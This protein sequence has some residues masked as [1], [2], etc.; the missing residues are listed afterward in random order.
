MG[1]LR[2]LEAYGLPPGPP[3]ADGSESRRTYAVVTYGGEACDATHGEGLRKVYV[4]KKAGE[5]AQ[6]P[7][8]RTRSVV[9]CEPQY[10][11]TFQARAVV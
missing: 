9:G 2:V 1:Q 10:A 3:K 5:D 4:P 8:T 6:L 7:Q 11:T